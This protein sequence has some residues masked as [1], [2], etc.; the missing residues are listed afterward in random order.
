MH[1]IIDIPSVD[2]LKTKSEAL[3]KEIPTLLP[4]T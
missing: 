1:Y 3:T 4:G 2:A